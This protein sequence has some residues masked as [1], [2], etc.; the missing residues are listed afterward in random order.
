[1]LGASVLCAVFLTGFQLYGVESNEVCICLDHLSSLL[2]DITQTFT[3]MPV[4]NDPL[5]PTPHCLS[6]FVKP[7]FF[8]DQNIHMG[9]YAQACKYFM[10]AIETKSKKGYHLF[11]LSWLVGW[12]VG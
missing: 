9:D 12:L 7:F 1:M 6:L 4:A 11:N 5:P 8:F 2:L 10:Q 3:C